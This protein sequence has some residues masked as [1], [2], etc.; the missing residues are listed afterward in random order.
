MCSCLPALALVP[1][2]DGGVWLV[3]EAP[4][5]LALPTPRALTEHD[6]THGSV[7]PQECRP[8]LDFEDEADLG[9]CEIPQGEPGHST[10]P[11]HRLLLM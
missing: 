1:H 8:P 11:R 4:P 9:W 3:E 10:A 6:L 7:L 2:G 5:V